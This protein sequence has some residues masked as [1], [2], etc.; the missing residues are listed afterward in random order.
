MQKSVKMLN[1]PPKFNQ[2]CRLC[3]TVVDPM[4]IGSHD[5]DE[6]VRKLSI[7]AKNPNPNDKMSNQKNVNVRN[8][9]QINKKIK[10]SNE[11]SISLSGG[12]VGGSSASAINNGFIVDDSDDDIGMRIFQILSIEVSPKT[13]QKKKTHSIYLRRHMATTI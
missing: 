6:L 3:M 11:I 8:D 10:R 9:D 1:L 5:N 7:F 4:K 2:I 12:G 13:K